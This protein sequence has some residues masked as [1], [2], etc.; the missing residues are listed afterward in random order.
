ML[1]YPGVRKER[2]TCSCVHKG[3]TIKD[4]FSGASRVPVIKNWRVGHT[5]GK[6][7]QELELPEWTEGWRPAPSAAEEPPSKPASA[8]E[9][10]RF[11]L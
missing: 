2:K 6:V 5:V 1:Y 11:S 9:Q 7:R 4:D 10:K 3:H 8:E